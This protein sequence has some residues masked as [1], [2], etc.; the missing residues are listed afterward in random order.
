M[1][2]PTPGF[3]TS[4]R[5][6]ISSWLTPVLI[7]DVLQQRSK[8]TQ[9]ISTTPN[10][11][12]TYYRELRGILDVRCHVQQ[13]AKQPEKGL[14]MKGPPEVRIPAK[15]LHLVKAMC[16]SAACIVLALPLCAYIVRT[17]ARGQLQYLILSP[18]LIAGV[19]T[20]VFC[21]LWGGWALMRLVTN[22]PAVI[23]TPESLI[24]H[25]IVYHVVMPWEEIESF[26]RF[27]PDTNGKSENFFIVHL[28]DRDRVCAAQQPLTRVL[29]R[30]FKAVRPTNISTEATRGSP[31]AVWREL[32]RYAHTTPSSDRI[33]FVTI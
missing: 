20:M 28:R 15:R 24:N 8:D 4:A 25:S 19:V 12:V 16:I 31:E 2:S 32:Q 7:A 26:T 33:K 21:L 5:T 6:E 17:L 9:S 23:L 13:L 22:L 14:P 27:Q 11:G 10:I 1:L 3:S 30:V 18:L 29:L